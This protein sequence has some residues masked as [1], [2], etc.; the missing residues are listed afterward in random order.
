M[1]N[2][3]LWNVATSYKA[4]AWL[5]NGMLECMSGG[6]SRAYIYPNYVRYAY[7][8]VL[9]NNTVNFGTPS[10]TYSS[11]TSIYDI[12]L[13]ILFLLLIYWHSHL[14]SL[15]LFSSLIQY[16]SRLHP[17]WCALEKPFF[18]IPFFFP[19]GTSHPIFSQQ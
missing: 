16:C 3:V 17:W 13:Y 10:G 18:F 4:N 1:L 7:V 5:S 9:M 8:V 11:S 15:V 6:N 19:R 2:I 14:I 12:F